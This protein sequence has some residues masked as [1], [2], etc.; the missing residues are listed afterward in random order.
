[1]LITRYADIHCHPAMKAI[2]KSFK[3]KSNR[4][5]NSASKFCKYSIWHKDA[6]TGFDRFLN[7]TLSLTKFTQSDF[8]SLSNGSVGLVSACLGPPEKGFVKTR[9]GSGIFSLLLVNLVTCIPFK[10]LRFLAKTG[11]YFREIEKEMDYYLAENNKPSLDGKRYKLVN[12]ATGLTDS[13]D[14]SGPDIQVVF[15]IEG[16]NVFDKGMD[17]KRDTA[18]R[19]TVIGNINRVKNWDYP[20]LWVSIGHHFFNELCGHAKSLPGIVKILIN[21]K[22]DMGTGITPFG[23]EVIGKLLESA[24]NSRKILIDIKH[25][26]D[27]SRRDFYEFCET[28]YQTSDPAVWD[29]LVV[30]HAACNGLESSETK[31]NISGLKDLQGDFIHEQMYPQPIN[32]YDEDIVKVAGSKGIIGMMLDERRL[33][34]K[35]TMKKLKKNIRRKIPLYSG[36]N[37]SA[38]DYIWWSK[39]VWDNLYYSAALLKEYNFSNCWDFQCIGSDF[40]GM[41]NP[42]DVFWTADDMNLLSAGL[43]IHA[44][45]YQAH[46]DG[47]LFNHTPE[48]VVNKIMFENAFNF[49]RQQL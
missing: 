13:T 9:M 6:P 10:R 33:A 42:V 24:T 35:K 44:E 36:D 12:G 17:P 30:S 48:E 5:K 16:A 46:P 40:D 4:F 41:I 43:M 31:K 29:P 22:M 27:E 2:G 37:E 38:K 14:P 28:F 32:L 47:G 15:S 8:T 45:K 49:I 20:P 39:P 19:N 23:R 25:M 26:S 21:Q 34:A 3:K 11:S 18:I 7:R 1:M